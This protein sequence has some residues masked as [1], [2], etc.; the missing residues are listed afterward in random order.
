MDDY[1]S[2]PFRSADLAG[3]LDRWLGIGAPL[4]A[5]AEERE[6]VAA[7]IASLRRLEEASGRTIVEEVAE[8]FV[9]RGRQNVEAIRCAL[10]EADAARVATAA[11]AL[12]GSAGLLGAGG[13]AAKA[14]DLEVLAEEDRLDDCGERLPGLEEELQTVIRQLGTG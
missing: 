5:P 2:K 10:A 4:A 6:D 1:L 14:R 3:M 13:L 9:S 7:R 11:H 8:S 12:V